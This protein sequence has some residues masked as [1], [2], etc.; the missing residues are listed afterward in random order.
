MG[1]SVDGFWI[2]FVYGSVQL[3]MVDPLG[4]IFEELFKLM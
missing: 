2:S 4:L 3:T 1:F